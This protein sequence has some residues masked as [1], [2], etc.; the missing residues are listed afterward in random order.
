MQVSDFYE[1]TVTDVL[2]INKLMFNSYSRSYT[3][4]TLEQLHKNW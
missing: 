1:I 2:K 3:L 4:D